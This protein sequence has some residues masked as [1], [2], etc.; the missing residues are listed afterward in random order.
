MAPAAAG[1]VPTAAGRGRTLTRVF[2]GSPDAGI[3]GGMKPGSVASF[4]TYL[5]FAAIVGVGVWALIAYVILPGIDAYHLDKYARELE[6]EGE[7]E[8]EIPTNELRLPGPA[9]EKM[10][11]YGDDAVSFLIPRLG[12]IEY[13][14]RA[15][16]WDA[17]KK[18][19]KNEE[20]HFEPG[21]SP[22]EN[23][24]AVEKLKVWWQSERKK[25]KEKKTVPPS[26]G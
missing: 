17:I 16:A 25:R 7:K 12:H 11:A 23:R 6:K 21:A 2:P 14:V 15:K 8:A 18:I 22:Y 5:M 9:A 4:F 1:G 26:E 19:V 24:E 13:R 3:I 10:I 20:L